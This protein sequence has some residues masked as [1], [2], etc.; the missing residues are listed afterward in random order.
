MQGKKLNSWQLRRRMALVLLAGL[1][2]ICGTSVRAAPN[3]HGDDDDDADV[4][5]TAV[6]DSI[7]PADV[8]TPELQP[9]DTHTNDRALSPSTRPPHNKP[10]HFSPPTRPPRAALCRSNR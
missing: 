5:M 6:A 9:D 7:A 8:Q 2:L 3:A 1:L 4:A 10:P